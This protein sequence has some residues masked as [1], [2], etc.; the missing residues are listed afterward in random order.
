MFFGYGKSGHSESFTFALSVIG[1][2]TGIKVSPHDLRRT[3]ASVAATCSIPPIALKLLIAHSVGSDVTSGYQ[4]FSTEQLRESAQAVADRF[5]EL[6]AIEAPTGAN[7][8]LLRS[9]AIHS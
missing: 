2:S 6:C 4:V 5:K 7:V 1:H 3:Y 8:S 9:G